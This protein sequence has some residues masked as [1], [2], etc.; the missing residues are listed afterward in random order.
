MEYVSALSDLEQ[1]HGTAVTI[2]KFDGLH[3][4]HRTLVENVLR[5]REKGRK[6]VLA[7][8]DVNGQWILSRE[9][10]RRLLERLDLDLLVELAFTPDLRDMSAED[11]VKE[12]L[13]GKLGATYVTVGQSFRFGK[14]RAG[15]AAFLSRMGQELGFE[16]VVAP[17]VMDGPIKVS[18]TTVRSELAK[19]CMERVASLMGTAYFAEGVVIHGSGLGGKKLL[20]TIN[21][22]PPEEKLLPPRG[23][24][25]T[26]T[27]FPQIQASFE[28]V[29]NIGVKPTVGGDRLGIET[30]LF[31][32]DQDL[33]GQECLTEFFHFCRPEK[34]Y[35]SIPEL[36]KELL[37]DV[38]EGRRYFGTLPI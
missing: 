13:L 2:G 8:I 36:K 9:E 18:S 27:H 30:H 14:G 26:R 4:G 16:V 22:L 34:N 32:V 17:S 19:G 31:D 6:A 1:M 33:Y 15:D 10:R 29:T 37:L 11:F 35:G 7:A 12:I 20:P 3:R 28:G 25:F 38:E 23:V 5:Q 21:I 24:Y